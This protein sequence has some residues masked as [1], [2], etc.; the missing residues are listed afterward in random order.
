MKASPIR[1]TL[2]PSECGPARR[3]VAQMQITCKYNWQFQ[4]ATP[5]FTQ[6]N[7]PQISKNPKKYFYDKCRKTGI[8]PE[9][10]V[11]YAW[12][13]P[14]DSRSLVDGCYRSDTATLH[15]ES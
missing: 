7:A 14:F 12:A 11:I 8:H 9:S 15:P 4:E 2:R 1:T 10:I 6:G 5:D 3:H 13:M